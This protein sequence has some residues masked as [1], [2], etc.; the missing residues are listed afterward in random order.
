MSRLI[1][2][3]DRISSLRRKLAALV[4]LAV[5]AGVGAWLTAPIGVV[6]L[7]RGSAAGWALVAVGLLLALACAGLI[8]GA[9][10]VRA[11]VAPQSRPG[12]ANPGFDEPVPSQDPVPGY[13]WTGSYLGS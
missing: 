2:E 13:S 10:R 12:K 5:L 1:E 7:A 8:V 11:S 4:V 6:L 3:Y 9:V